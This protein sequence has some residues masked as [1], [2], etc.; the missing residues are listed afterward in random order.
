MLN[1]NIETG[2]KVNIFGLSLHLLYLKLSAS[3][4]SAHFAGDWPF[5]DF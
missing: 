4:P 3:N 2:N 1:P 5:F